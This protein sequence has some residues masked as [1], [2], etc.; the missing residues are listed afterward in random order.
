[1]KRFVLGLVLASLALPVSAQDHVLLRLE[2]SPRHHEWVA[3]ESGGRQVHTFVVYPQSSAKATAVIVI[4][5]NKGLTDW[6]RGVADQLAEAGYIAL[7][8]DL[9]SGSGPD[10][11]KTSDFVE[12]ARVLRGRKV[13][14]DTFGVPA[15]PEIVHDLQSHA[16][17]TRRCGRSWSMP[18]CV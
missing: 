1:M 18:A 12:F 2:K 7:A 14:I 13:K 5:E 10:G 15:T 8:P 4:H 17:V 3:I 6:V 11:G 9:L 16:G